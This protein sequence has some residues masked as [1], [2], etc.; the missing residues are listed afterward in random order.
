[1]K[2]WP[3]PLY[4]ILNLWSVFLGHPVE[5]RNFLLGNSYCWLRDIS[6]ALVCGWENIQTSLLSQELHVWVHGTDSWK[7]CKSKYEFLSSN[8]YTYFRYEAKE[9]GFCP[10]GATLHSMMT[11]HGIYEKYFIQGI[12]KIFQDL[13]RSVSM[14]G[15]KR[16]LNQSK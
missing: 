6:T 9:E 15:L 12:L 11:P 14:I 16:S 2:K 1:M 3:P 5:L 4:V 8:Y 7:V 10:G 13:M